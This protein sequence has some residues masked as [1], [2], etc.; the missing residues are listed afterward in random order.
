MHEWDRP[1][2]MLGASSLLGQAL[3]HAW[4]KLALGTGPSPCL[5]QARSWDRPFSVLG[6]CPLLGQALHVANMP[7][8]WLMSLIGPMFPV[9]IYIR[10]LHIYILYIERDRCSICVYCT[11][12]FRSA[13]SALAVMSFEHSGMDCGCSHE[14]IHWEM[15]KQNTY[16]HIYIYIHK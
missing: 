3:Q 13:R 15:R 5:G 1:F 6:T 8:M 16:T 14:D 4:G 7:C 9:R 2:N 11:P 10:Y 12:G